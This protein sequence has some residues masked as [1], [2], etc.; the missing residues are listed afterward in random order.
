MGESKIPLFAYVDESGNTGKNIFD[1]TQ[2]DFLTAAAVTKGDFDINF[3]DAVRSLAKRVGV[4]AIHANELG[5]RGIE[6]IAEDLRA[7]LEAAHARFF[8]SR[9]EKRYLLAAKM[10][11]VLFDSG[12]NAA[13]AWHHYNVR[14]LR[15]MLAFKLAGIVDDEIASEFW[16]CLL[17]SREEDA[18]AKFPEICEALKVRL[19]IIP[20]Q[21]SRQVIGDGL[22][23]IIKHP[24]AIHLMT[25]RKIAKQGH[26]PNLV[27]F[28]NLLQGLH[29]L[30]DTLNRKIVR[31]THDEQS[32]FS[33]TLNSWHEMFSNASPDALR[34][35]G[36]EFSMRMVP[37]SEFTIKSDAD[38]PGIQMADAALWLY[39]QSLKGKRLPPACARDRRHPHERRCA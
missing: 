12:E 28:A 37:G 6:P 33:R 13:V 4:D 26:F 35:A 23:W 3:G 38:S 17:L 31:I 39:A 30:S 21:K 5:Y 25:E 18:R 14:P 32:E 1:E 9:V 36:E 24:E 27:A 7:V 34:W 20:D 11:D 2:P 8:V 10:F 16:K 22:D 15:I 19:P 29:T